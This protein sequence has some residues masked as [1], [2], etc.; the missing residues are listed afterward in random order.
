MISNVK[1]TQLP[2]TNINK[3]NGSKETRSKAKESA[4]ITDCRYRSEIELLSSLEM[5]P[6]YLHQYVCISEI[7]S[8]ATCN[9]QYNQERYKR[10]RGG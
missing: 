4:R 8:C 2:K 10:Q 7:Q 9:E 3:G 1:Y 6:A 5:K